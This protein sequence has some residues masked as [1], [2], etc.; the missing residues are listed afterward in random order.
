MKDFL[1]EIA[2]KR[3]SDIL[4]F[5]SEASYEKL[6]EE[7]LNNWIEYEPVK[8]NVESYGAV[9]GSNNSINF[10]GFTLYAV[11]GYGV[12]RAG[13]VVYDIYAG[14]IDILYPPGDGERIDLL[15]EIVEAKVT[16][17]LSDLDLLLVDGSI[18]SLL[19]EPRPL[20][21]LV[22]LN[23]VLI[24]IKELLGENFYIDFWNNVV[25]KLD[26]LRGLRRIHDP[27]V[28]REIVLKNKLIS[29]EH[30]HMVAFI[31]YLEKLYTLRRVLEETIED[32]PKIAYLSKTSRSQIYFKDMVKAIGEKTPVFSDIMLFTYFTSK[33]GYSKP[34]LQSE[35]GRYKSF[36]SDYG[37]DELL[38]RFYD[39][40]DFIITYVR[41]VDQGPVFKLEIPI[42]T[43]SM[44]GRNDVVKRMMDQML[45]LI[46]NGY[47]YP[48][49][50]ANTFSKITR[51]DMELIASNL[52]LLQTP[53]GREV[54]YEWI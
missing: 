36:P 7:V 9:D 37:L 44:V 51:K 10:K 4:R 15:R 24:G 14:D 25:E 50:E 1:L 41:L 33:P 54:L 53:T 32:Y 21:D 30:Q 42:Y 40:L 12:A 18:R 26:N 35:I 38:G 48:L 16:Y 22:E 11:A 34:K 28:K 49:I 39:K 45:P 19:I 46:V 5:I 23:K 31:E 6:R 8:M 20:N 52:G 17:L 3:S 43:D 13:D 2:L 27:I 29:E 47:P